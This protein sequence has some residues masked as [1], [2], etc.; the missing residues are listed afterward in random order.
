MESIS[1]IMELI[2]CIES[3]GKTVRIHKFANTSNMGDTVL[4]TKDNV[5]QKF[6]DSGRNTWRVKIGNSTE[7]AYGTTMIDAI[8]CAL[9]QGDK[10][11]QV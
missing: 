10:H 11:G 4:R 3:T 6:G 5:Y 1:E 7:W 2:R 8:R 9:K